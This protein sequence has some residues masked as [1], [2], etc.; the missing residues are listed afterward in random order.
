[1]G[2]VNRRIEVQAGQSINKLKTLFKK[3]LKQK[4]GSSSRAP[5]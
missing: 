3:E 5:A 2:S 1:M 4:G